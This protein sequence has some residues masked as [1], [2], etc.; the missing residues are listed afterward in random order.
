M[1]N[2]KAQ[3]EN[4]RTSWKTTKPSWKPTEPVGKPQWLV[5]KSE[6][7]VRKP[8]KQLE[9]Q[10]TRLENHTHTGPV[11]KPKN[12]LESHKKQLKTTKNNSKTTNSIWETSEIVSTCWGGVGE[13]PNQVMNPQNQ[14]G[15]PQNQV[16]KPQEPGGKQQETVKNTKPLGRNRAESEKTRLQ[17]CLSSQVSSPW[18]F[19]ESGHPWRKFQKASGQKNVRKNSCWTFFRPSKT[20]NGSCKPIFAT[21]SDLATWRSKMCVFWMQSKSRL[22]CLSRPVQED[23]SFLK[24]TLSRG[25]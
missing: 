10:R 1:E 9:N 19:P 7:P 14:I 8:R 24:R 15:K 18:T 6:E 20:Q 16:G 21:Y 4:H 2:H 13:I 25:S 17:F 23:K 5:G 12:H 22:N 11:W 3:L